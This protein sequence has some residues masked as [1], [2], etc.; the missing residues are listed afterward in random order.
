LRTWF[1]LGS[2]YIWNGTPDTS[3]RP[4]LFFGAPSGAAKVWFLHGP[5]LPE[6][7]RR[8]Q[9]LCG[10]TPL[11]P[12]WALGHH[13]CRWGYAGP[14]DLR[15]VAE[16]LRQ[17]QIPNDGLWL[18]IDYMDGFR[19]FTLNEKTFRNPA[20]ELAALTRQGQRVVAIIDPGVKAEKGYQVCEEG[21][22]KDMFCRTP[23]GLP[24]SGY[25]WPG[26]TYFPDFSLPAVREWWAGYVEKF[27][28]TGFAGSWNDMNDPSI[29][30]VD[31]DAMLFHKGKW[32]HEAWH[33]QYALGMA[34]ATREGFQRARPEERPFV[35][36]RSASTGSSR[37]TAVWC[38]DNVSNWHNL[39]Q[40]IPVSLNL[41]LSGIP[42]NGPDVCGFAENTTPQL[43]MAWYQA[44]F[45]FP[46]FRNHTSIHTKR[47]EP[48]ALGPRALKV[49][50]RYIRLRYTLMPYL[51]QLFAAQ[52]ESGEAILRPLFYDFPESGSLE[53][54]RVQD[55][56]MVGPSILQAPLL[57]EGKLER[58]VALPGPR[59]WFCA[60]TGRWQR[61][62]RSIRVRTPADQ[63]P[64]YFRANSLIPCRGG[65]IVDNRTDL[66]Q[67]E[68]HCFMDGSGEAVLRYVSDDGLSH[69][70]KSGARSVF[71]FRAR[72]RGQEVLEVDVQVESKGY[73]SCRVVFVHYGSARELRLHLD[74]NS[75]SLK[76]GASRRT[77]TGKS[78]PV[79]TTEPITLS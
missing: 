41:A 43:A 33:N 21:L 14:G 46:F 5:S 36:S 37:Y 53:L 62:G 66:R 78:I 20:K 68:V 47:Q 44:G 29:G 10:P 16:G 45:L 59:R 1:D 12:L 27:G 35:L 49:I 69:A 39:R 60:R 58:T 4:S 7:T 6:L 28:R 9:K 8:F 26:R 57:E 65:E 22:A 30:P 34:M 13:Q 25:V 48:W 42:F 67:I 70:Y 17:H 38:G 52:E 56:F 19:V 55:Q 11:P 61:G 71:E 72:P 2:N 76:L 73:G 63:T 18:D 15:T 79:R 51:Y 32:P 31:P 64:L 54:D 75:R 50:R 77:W 40:A 74:G 3:S 24:F 23:D